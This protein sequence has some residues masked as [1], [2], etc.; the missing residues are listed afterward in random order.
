MLNTKIIEE[1]MELLTRSNTYST[2]KMGVD[3]EDGTV[4]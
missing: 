3:G 1:S 4:M 2:Y